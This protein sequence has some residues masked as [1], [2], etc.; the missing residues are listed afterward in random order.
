MEGPLVGHDVLR[1]AVRGSMRRLS[2]TNIKEG[3][4][5]DGSLT[6]TSMNT[7]GFCR[8][9]F[10]QSANFLLQLAQPGT[11]VHLCSRAIRVSRVMRVIRVII[12][13]LG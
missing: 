11:G 3:G 2:H 5:R 10:A 4:P 6:Q 13:F 8:T 7:Q 9:P 12:G 1:V